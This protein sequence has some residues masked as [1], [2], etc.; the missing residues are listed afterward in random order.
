MRPCLPYAREV[1]TTVQVRVAVLLV[2]GTVEWR[3]TWESSTH[4]CVARCPCAQERTSGL[5]QQLQ[6]LREAATGALEE[7]RKEHQ[8]EVRWWG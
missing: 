7:A 1:V 5:E 3:W 4:M 8:E 6:E 2:V